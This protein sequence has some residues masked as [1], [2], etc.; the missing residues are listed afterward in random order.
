MGFPL[1]CGLFEIISASEALPADRI[2]QFHDI[3]LALQRLLPLKR[4]PLF[5]SG[6][7]RLLGERE[8]AVSRLTDDELLTV[9]VSR[10]KGGELFI[11]PLRRPE[12]TR[13]ATTAPPATEK[14]PIA[15]EEARNAKEL[16]LLKETMAQHGTNKIITYNSALRDKP[17]LTAHY[18]GPESGWVKMKGPN[19]VID[20]V[21][22]EVHYF[23]NVI[24]GRIVEWK[25][26]RK[27][28]NPGHPVLY[29]PDY[30]DRG[31]SPLVNHKK[32]G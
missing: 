21:G 12:P 4:D 20:F 24:S 32:Q 6:L 31:K 13:T 9:A 14:G 23:K 15:N 5:M 28:I 11:R 26:D 10:I 1:R 8:F 7:R 25:F 2:R 16:L 29:A 27:P 30:G 18:G 17:R 22:T 3:S 19:W